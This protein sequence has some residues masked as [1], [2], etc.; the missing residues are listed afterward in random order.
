M[1]NSNM[2]SS[3]NGCS[4]VES[5]ETEVPLPHLP[6]FR[7]L[8]HKEFLKTNVVDVWLVFFPYVVIYRV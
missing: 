4:H 6:K 1:G 2:V 5:H 3:W 8:A 7:I